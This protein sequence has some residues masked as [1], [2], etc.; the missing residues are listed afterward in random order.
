MFGSLRKPDTSDLDEAIARLMIVLST[1]DPESEEY[2]KLLES[3]ER[4]YALKKDYLPTRVSADAVFAVVGN[5]L[6]IAVIVGYEQKH[7]I[8]SKALGFIM[9]SK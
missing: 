6:G 5:L 7:V 4:L 1:K 8:T 9:K 3:I 2:S